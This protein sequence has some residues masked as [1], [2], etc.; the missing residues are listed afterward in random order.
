MNIKNQV[1]WSRIKDICRMLPSSLASVDVIAFY[2]TGAYS[3]SCLP[4]IRYNSNT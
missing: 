2:T 3:N 1:I 4:D